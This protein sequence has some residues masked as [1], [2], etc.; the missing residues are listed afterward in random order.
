MGQKV[1]PE[2]APR[3]LHPRLEV[4]LVQREELLRLPP[5]GHADPPAHHRPAV[6][7]R[8]VGHHDPQERHRGRGQ[9]PH[10][11]AGDRDRQVRLRGRSAAARPAPDH[12][13]AGQG[14][15]P[16][17]QASGARRATGRA[18]DRRAAP[19][20]RR[21]PPRDEARAHQRDALWRQGRQGPG[22]RPARRRRDGAHRGLLGRPRAAAHAARRH[23]LRL[24]RGAH[25]VRADRR[26]VLDQQGRDHARGLHRRRPDEHGRALAAG[27]G[28]RRPRRT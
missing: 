11:A 2:G 24:P 4:E 10:R 16:R 14:Q 1:H 28:S 26:Q 3:R 19:E 5:R 15:H 12:R 21:V 17:D 20:P 6:A 25:H 8:P 7:R 9:H 18:V 27:A 23:R 13:Q 22:L